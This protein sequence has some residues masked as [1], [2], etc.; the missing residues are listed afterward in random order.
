MGF[1]HEHKLSLEKD[2]QTVMQGGKTIVSYPLRFLF[3]LEKSETT[4]FQVAISVPKKRFHFAVDRNLEK[5]R[6]RECIRA[7]YKSED[8]ENLSLKMLIVFLDSNHH[9]Q[10]EL[11]PLVETAFK[12]IQ[13]YAKNL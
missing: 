5:R 13:Q 11:Q 8:F 3:V 2:F 10:S 1:L 12:K 9:Q 6:I 7:T 4:N